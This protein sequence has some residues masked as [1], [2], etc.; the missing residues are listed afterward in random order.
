MR[1]FQENI[2]LQEKQDLSVVPAG[3]GQFNQGPA[4]FRRPL[5]VNMSPVSPNMSPSSVVYHI[6]KM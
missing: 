3:I 2:A 4:G 6:L 1:A 5:M